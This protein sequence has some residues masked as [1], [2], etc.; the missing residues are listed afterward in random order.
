MWIAVIMPHVV[1]FATLGTSSTSTIDF[2]PTGKQ[3]I[4]FQ[5]Q[6]NNF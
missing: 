5:S 2:E 1:I 4:H 3:C 6:C